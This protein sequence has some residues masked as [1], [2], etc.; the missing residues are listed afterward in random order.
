MDDFQVI[1]DKMNGKVFKLSE[2][3]VPAGLIED[4]RNQGRM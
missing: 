3:K 1:L 4:L 2:L